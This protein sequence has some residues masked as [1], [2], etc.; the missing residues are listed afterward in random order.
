MQQFLQDAESV[1]GADAIGLLHLNDASDIVGSCQ[2]RHAII[3]DGTIGQEALSVA[4]QHHRALGTP[5]IIEPPVM[6]DAALKELYEKVKI[7]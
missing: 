7:W 5:I 2:D 1:V 4:Y 3:G 6:S